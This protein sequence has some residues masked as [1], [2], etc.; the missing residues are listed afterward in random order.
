L[1]TSNMSTRS[2]EFANGSRIYYDSR[3]GEVVREFDMREGDDQLI[4][5]PA[6]L[7]LCRASCYGGGHVNRL[8]VSV[9]RKSEKPLRTLVEEIG[10]RVKQAQQARAAIDCLT[11]HGPGKKVRQ[12]RKVFREAVRLWRES[13][14]P[15]RAE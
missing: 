9:G 2:I 10:K 15:K 11:K 7:L 12:L 3:L 1:D 4:P 13:L 6:M 14:V 5:Q 8:A